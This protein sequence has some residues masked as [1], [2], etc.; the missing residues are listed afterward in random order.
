MCQYSTNGNPAVGVRESDPSWV[1]QSDTATVDVNGHT[2]DIALRFQRIYHPF[3]L[4]LKKFS[5][6]RYT[7]THTAKN[8]SSLVQFKNPENLAKEGSFLVR[9]EAA[10]GTPTTTLTRVPPRVS[11]RVGSRACPSRLVTGVRTASDLPRS[12]RARLTT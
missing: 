9:A 12:N 3:T 1:T 5:F 2:Y 6:D 8:Y 10:S 11:S 7:G 4:S